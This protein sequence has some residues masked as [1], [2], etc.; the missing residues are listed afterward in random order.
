MSKYRSSRLSVPPNFSSTRANVRVS[1]RSGTLR[2]L[3]TPGASNVAAITG[4]ADETQVAG[5]GSPAYMSPQQVKEHPLNHQTDIYSLGVVMY[6]L[7]TGV[8]P[9]HA[10]NNYSMM[11]Q[12]ANTE[13]APPFERVECSTRMGVVMPPCRARSCAW[14]T[15]R[16][17]PR[18]TGKPSIGFQASFEGSECLF[19]RYL[20][21]SHIKHDAQ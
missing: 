15:A 11:Y 13:P 5:I 20:N 16:I 8:L 3:C 17:Q 2:S 9:F 6:Q 19:F 21:A 1:S 4:S 10:S 12:I 7:L 14:A 18:N